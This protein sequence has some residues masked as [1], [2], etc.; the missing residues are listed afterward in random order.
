MGAGGGGFFM[1]FCPI[2]SKTRVRKAL[3]AEGLREM[4][5]D[6]DFDGAKVLVNF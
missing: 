1:F 6:F 2:Q 4:T 3:A 5:Y